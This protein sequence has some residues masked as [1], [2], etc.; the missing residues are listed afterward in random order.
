MFRSARHFE[1]CREIEFGDWLGI[2]QGL[3]EYLLLQQIDPTRMATNLK[4]RSEEILEQYSQ[5]NLLRELD[6][7]LN[8]IESHVTARSPGTS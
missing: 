6:A 1:A 8:Q 3:Q 5:A 2:I 7:V 4:V